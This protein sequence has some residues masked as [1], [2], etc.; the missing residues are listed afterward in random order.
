M[1]I[2]MVCYPT[3][4][5]SG[6]LATELG[7]A[8]ADEG[9]EVHFISSSQPFRLQHAFHENLMFHQVDDF[10]YPLFDNSPYALLL[11][12]KMIEVI[13]QEKLDVMHVHYAMPHAVSAI[14]AAQILKDDRIPIVTTLHGT[15]ITLVGQD[16][17]FFE[18]TKFCID[19][20]TV[21]NTVSDWLKDETENVFGVESELRRVYNFVDVNVLQRKKIKC[22]GHLKQKNDEC[23]SFIHLSNFREV[24]RSADAVR[25]FAK[26][27]SQVPNSRLLL[28]GE[29][30]L[31]RECRRLVEEF[32]L[33]DKVHFL[34]KQVD[35]VG[36]LS[37]ADVM[38]FPSSQESFG[39][40]AIEA[41]AM[42]IPV[43]ASNAGGIPE[44]I[45]CG[46]TGFLTEVGDVDKMAEYGVKLAVDCELRTKIGKAARKH[47]KSHFSPSEILKQYV[48]LYS[49]A[50]SIEGL[51]QN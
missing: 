40:A 29:G 10:E 22:G 5:G 9:H 13:R 34:G 25:A 48:K 38:F 46:E 35:L 28:A 43:I 44:V 24:K 36:V 6:V 41:G 27:H 37:M 18:M 2:G 23:I 49:D 31:I 20:S 32:G 15:D 42:E 11:T 50:I 26:V 21:V 30:P 17:A 4:G 51:K 33:A 1:K 16:P 7:K 8:L 45:L 14:L 12:A 3:Y 19:N 39:L 47:V